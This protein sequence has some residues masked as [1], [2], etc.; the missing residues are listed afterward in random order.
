[1]QRHNG[2]GAVNPPDGQMLNFAYGKAIDVER[3]EGEKSDRPHFQSA[4]DS[5]GDFI[6]TFRRH[7]R[8]IDESGILLG[9]TNKP[10]DDKSQYGKPDK[11]RPSTIA[12]N[13]F[14]RHMLGNSHIC[15]RPIMQQRITSC[16]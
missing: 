11:N 1:M 15:Q 4:S 9:E 13:H 8:Q 7:A 2:D 10:V 3:Q 5:N 12:V 6:M 14:P 16:Q